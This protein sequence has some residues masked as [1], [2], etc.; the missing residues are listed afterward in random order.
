MPRYLNGAAMM[1]MCAMLAGGCAIGAGV[2]GASALALTAWIALTFI[3]V[4]AVATDRVVYGV[5]AGQGA[6]TPVPAS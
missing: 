4:G 2:I 3:W 6:G 1:G 5:G